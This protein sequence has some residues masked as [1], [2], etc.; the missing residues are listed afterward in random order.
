MKQV[1]EISCSS[2]AALYGTGVFTT[3]AIVRGEPLF[4]DRH[5]ARLQANANATGISMPGNEALLA[6]LR[7]RLAESSLS[8]GRARI[9]LYE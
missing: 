7:S 6:A 4:W 5:V 3:I 2:N 1:S 9:T 8:D